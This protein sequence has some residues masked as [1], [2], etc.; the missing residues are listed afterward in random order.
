MTRLKRCGVAAATATALSLTQL[1]AAQAKHEDGF[2]ARKAANT[3]A[4]PVDRAKAEPR[5]PTNW[6]IP[7][8]GPDYHGSNGG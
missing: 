4:R 7:E 2:A 6:F 5:L 1:P 8:F 3:A